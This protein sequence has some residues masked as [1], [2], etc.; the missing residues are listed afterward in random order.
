MRANPVGTDTSDDPLLA[1][2]ES[3]ESDESAARVSIDRAMVVARRPSIAFALTVLLGIVYASVE[4]LRKN[5]RDY[6]PGTFS[7]LVLVSGYFLAFGMRWVLLAITEDLQA[8]LTEARLSQPNNSDSH[9]EDAEGSTIDGGHEPMM[10]VAS[11]VNNVFRST[12]CIASAVCGFGVGLLL[13]LVAIPV[14]TQDKVLQ[15]VFAVFFAVYAAMGFYGIPIFMCV[16]IEYHKLATRLQC[17]LF[18]R[19]TAGLNHMRRVT[20]VLFALL[21]LDFVP[22]ELAFIFGQFG[23]SGSNTGSVT[24]FCIIFG[25]FCILCMV[26]ILVVPLLPLHRQLQAKQHT[27]VAKWDAICERYYMEASA[28]VAAGEGGAVEAT[29]KMQAFQQALQTRKSVGSVWLLPLGSESV[30]TLG[31][32]IVISITPAVISLILKERA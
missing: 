6:R 28:V 17:D 19:H 3:G 15:T 26:A 31:K 7:G 14:W 25:V 1:C 24:V 32:A 2:I 11:V 5:G 30:F 10:T 21:I 27:E 13:T 23:D 22:I 12:L 9:A 29:Q 18:E 8:V 20:S 4:A 16:L